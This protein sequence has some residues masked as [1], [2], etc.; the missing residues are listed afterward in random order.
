MT[1]GP[2]GRISIARETGS[3]VVPRTSLTT[4]RRCCVTALTRLD[5]PAL[6]QPKKPM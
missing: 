4:A 6:R 5:L 1:T 2:R 3:V